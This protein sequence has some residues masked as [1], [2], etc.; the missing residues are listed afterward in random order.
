MND[1][2]DLIAHDRA[3][4][5]SGPTVLL[6]HAGV[7][8]RRMW[9]PQW[10]GLTERFDVVRPDLRGF[11]DSATP[12][13]G[14]LDHVADVL[15]LLDSLGV[16][17]CHVVGSSFGAGVAV[18]L[19]LA[20]P[21][22]VVSL[23]LAPP[24][25]SLL[26]T[27]TPDLRAFVD[28]ERA[29]LADDDLDA[30]VEANVAAWVVGP[31]RREGAVDPAVLDLVRSMQRRA[32]EVAESLGDLDEVEAEVEPLD[33]I[34][35]IEVPVTL[36]VGGHDLATTH[37]AA[38]RLVAGLRHVRRLDWPDVAHLPSLEQPHRFTALLLEHLAGA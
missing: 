12:P 31:G 25:G 26:A 23:V 5:P 1:S 9:D 17:R 28:A 8:D 36:V 3:G 7:A 34:G 4:D 21:D 27:M 37:D 18:E 29:A 19:T 24:G 11:G 33:R 6:L 2:A 10:S 14:P 38:D 22:R 15:S 16:Q 20:A 32:F 30:A 13:S 35:E